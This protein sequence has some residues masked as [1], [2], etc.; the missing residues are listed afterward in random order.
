MAGGYLVQGA[1]ALAQH[2]AKEP[3]QRLHIRRLFATSCFREFASHRPQDTSLMI[4]AHTL[5]D[6]EGCS[7]NTAR[8]VFWQTARAGHGWPKG[9]ESKTSVRIA[10]LTAADPRA[11]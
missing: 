4:E 10:T 7:M 11:A 1:V 9:P 5:Q 3:L 2:N 8:T 6:H